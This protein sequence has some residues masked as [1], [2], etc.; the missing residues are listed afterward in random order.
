MIMQACRGS[1]ELWNNANENILK[2]QHVEIIT[3]YID[4]TEEITG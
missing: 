3:G 1:F 2:M 4:N